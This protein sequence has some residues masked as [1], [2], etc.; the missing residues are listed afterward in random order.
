MLN[1]S[2]TSST[3]EH[4]EQLCLQ[5]IDNSQDFT[6]SV[7]ISIEEREKVLEYHRKLQEQLAE[8]VQMITSNQEVGLSLAIQSIQEVARDFRKQVRRIL[9]SPLKYS[10][11]FSWN[12]WPPIV[13]RSFSAPTTR[14]FYSMNWKPTPWRIDWTFYKKPSIVSKSKRKSPLR[15]PHLRMRIPRWSSR[16]S[17][18]NC[19]NTSARAIN[20]KSQANTMIPYSSTYR[21]W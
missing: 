7:Y 2:P 12:K 15:F 11:T 17:W 4:L 8:I 1:V 20:C 19:W 9:P 10:A 21:I 6:D 14:V 13:L 16:F 18:A 3:K 5:T